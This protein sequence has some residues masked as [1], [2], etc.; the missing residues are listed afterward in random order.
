[1][2]ALASEDKRVV[3]Y[4]RSNHCLLVDYDRQEAANEILEFIDA[5]FDREAPAGEE[6]KPE[7]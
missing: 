4:T 5:R 2:D 1:M 7:S 3:S 6:T